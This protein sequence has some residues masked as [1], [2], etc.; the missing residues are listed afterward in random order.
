M[1]PIRRTSS[2]FVMGLLIGAVGYWVFGLVYAVTGI[3]P[4][5]SLVAGLIPA[6]AALGFGL[7]QET[8]YGTR[9]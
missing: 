5:E 4:A 8:I 9:G 2:V 3:N 1:T 7:S 6:L